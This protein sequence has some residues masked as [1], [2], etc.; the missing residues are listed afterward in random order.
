MIVVINKAILHILDFNSGANVFSQQELDA[1][2]ASVSVFLAKHIEKLV[3]DPNAQ[4]GAFLPASEFKNRMADYLAGRLDFIGFSLFAAE[5]VYAATALSEVPEPADLVICDLTVDDERLLALLKCNNKVGFT[6]QVI[7]ADGAIKNDI[8]NHYAILPGL[9]Q[10][11]DEYAL[12][13]MSTLNIRFND[14]K[15]SV[16]GEGIYI[17]P[18]R[19]LSCSSS[20]SPKK[21][22]DMVNSIAKKVSETHGQSSV[23]AVT[24]AKNYLVENAEV[25]EY[26]DPIDL[27]RKIF[28]SSPL[29]QDEYIKEV[30]NACIP[31]TVKVDLALAM[32]K[33]KNHKIKTDTGIEIAFPADYFKNTDYIEIVNNPDGTLSIQLKNIG[34]IING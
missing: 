21:A 9:S 28:P 30:K 22:I 18:E 14:K 27:G 24:R 6:H 10:K 4:S 2:S 13:D 34:K 33:G 20:I 1:Q 31:D 32:K 12:I 26:L 23:T 15:R 7:T 11:I 5:L 19:V 8:I 16:D 29:M 3:S 17:L 25:S